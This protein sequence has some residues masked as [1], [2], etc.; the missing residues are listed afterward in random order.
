[1]YIFPA[2]DIL[3]GRVVRLRQGD[4]NE[5][6]EYSDNSYEVAKDFAKKGASHLHVVDLDGA[7]MGTPSNRDI[8]VKIASDIPLFIECGGGIRTER[9][10][11]AYLHNGIDRVILG[12]SAL[13]DTEFTKRMLKLYPEAIAIAV[14]ALNQKVAIEGWTSMTS[15]DS[16]EF[17]KVMQALG[18]KYI[19]YTDISK[20]G[21][22][23]GTNHEIY[24]QLAEMQGIS[25]TASGGISSLEEIVKLKQLGLYAAIVGK[26]VYS[27][28]IDIEKA[29]SI[30][31]E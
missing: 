15:V 16:I 22:S 2:I 23:E 5:V 25:I 14:D 20:D 19:I 28:L 1:M 27:G 12:S 21:L 3:N 26:A 17:C 13:R 18:A 29:I 11:E 31:K 24:T 6:T 9:D 7:R 30:A 8:I 10:V 4:Y